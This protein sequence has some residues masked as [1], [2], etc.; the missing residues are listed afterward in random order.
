MS[1]VKPW[2]QLSK[3]LLAHTRVFTLDAH[4]RQSATSG[5]EAEFY[6]ID[7]ADWVNVIALTADQKIVLVEQ[8]RHGV[9]RASLEIPGGMVD[10]GETPE[11]AARRELLEETGYASAAWRLI[12]SV[13][14]NPAIQ[15]NRCYTFLT[16]DAERVREPSP[17]A[18]EEIRVVLEDAASVPELLRSGR[19]DHALV[20]AAFHWWTLDASRESGGG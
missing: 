16:T 20:V 1:D 13:D 18:H 17:D 2:R 12:G 14:P 7:A 8:Y 5:V 9:E 19:I 15:T 3:R 4:T 11:A 10:D 6:V